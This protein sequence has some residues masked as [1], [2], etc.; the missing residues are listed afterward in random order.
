MPVQ[1]VARRSQ[2]TVENSA[3][4]RPALPVPVRACGPHSQ[5]TVENSAGLRP[6]LPVDSANSAG[7]GSWTVQDS[8]DSENLLK[9]ADILQQAVVR[10][11]RVEVVEA[12]EA[13]LHKARMVRQQLLETHE[14]ILLPVLADHHGAVLGLRAQTAADVRLADLEVAEQL[15]RR[16]ANLG[17]GG[18]GARGQGGKGARARGQG[19]VDGGGVDGVDGGGVDGDGKVKGAKGQGG[20]PA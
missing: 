17:Q 5:R 20:Q 4:L 1:A 6:A 3:G 12:A 16:G 8:A 19:G 7:A 9:T 10:A 18:K 11:G 13:L 15:A 14:L 2:R